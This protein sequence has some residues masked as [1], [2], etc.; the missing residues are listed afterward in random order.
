MV[1]ILVQ[2]QR[3]ILNRVRGDIMTIGEAKEMIVDLA[4]AV[5]KAQ[6]P[7]RNCAYAYFTLENPREGD[8]NGITCS[9]CKIDFWNRYK[10]QVMREVN[11]Y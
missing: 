5:A 4:V 6:V 9:K 2:L 1:N 8:C 7:D 3:L 11:K 10:I